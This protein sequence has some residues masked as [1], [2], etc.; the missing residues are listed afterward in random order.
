MVRKMRYAYS[1]NGQF[2]EID[3]FQDDLAGL[4]LADF[5]FKSKKEKGL[6]QQPD[7]CLVEVTQDSTMAGGML[8]GKKYSDIENHLR[9]L[10]YRALFLPR[11]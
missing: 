7:F 2:A 4:V 3:V 10:G 6:F 1:H 8:C 5:E 11:R 9:G